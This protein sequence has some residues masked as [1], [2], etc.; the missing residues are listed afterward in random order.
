MTINAIYDDERIIFL[1]TG[2]KKDLKSL[3]CVEISVE[4]QSHSYFLAVI[5]FV[6]NALKPLHILYVK[7]IHFTFLY[8]CINKLRSPR[9]APK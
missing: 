8:I 9:S 2:V 5:F 1:K 3:L 6:A 4:I 7:I